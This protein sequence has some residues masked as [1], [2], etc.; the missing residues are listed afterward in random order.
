MEPTPKRQFLFTPDQ[1]AQFGRDFCFL[2]GATLS[3]D[4]DTDEH[5]IPRWIQARYELWDQKLTLV[6]RTTIPYRQLTI[7]CC[8]S[9]NNDHLGK[10]EMEVQR[11]CDDGAQAVGNLPPITLFLWLGK[12]FYGLLYRSHL[13]EWNRV[14]PEGPIVPAELLQEFSLHHQFLQAARLPFEFLPRVPASLFVY[15]TL[16]PSN[17]KMGFD[18][19]DDL[20]AMGISIRVGKVGMICCLQDGGAVEYAFAP[21]YREYQQLRLHPQQ[22]AQ[23][24]S[25]VFYDLHRF[26]RTPKF[27]LVEGDERVHAYLSPLGGLT[28]GS[29]FDPVDVQDYARVLAHCS[30]LPLEVIQPE[31]GQLMGWLRDD[32]GA[33]KQMLPD[34]PV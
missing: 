21:R 18:F 16:Q 30:R 6:N 19:W 32:S 23:V 3:P 10:I 8:A 12:I 9:C 25:L 7:P 31:P 17:L 5:V 27:M 28:G 2:C 13:L 15:E 24:T 1:P 14:A 11:A 20:P 29:L 22:F 26:N 33:L 34:D 4:R